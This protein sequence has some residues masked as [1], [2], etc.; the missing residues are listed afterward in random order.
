MNLHDRVN[1][2]LPL[3]RK[4]GRYLGNETNAFHKPWERAQIRAAMIFPDLYEIGMSHLGLHILY[5]ILN[6]HEDVLADRAYRPDTDMEELLRSKGIPLYGL[7]SGKP[8]AAFDLLAITLPYELCY[9][10]IPAILDLSGIPLMASDR[11]D[12]ALPLVLGGGSCACNP[13]PVA[14]LFDAIVLG[15]GEEIII[16]ITKA[17]MTWKGTGLPRQELLDTLASIPGIYV[18]SFYNPVYDPQG[19]FT[20]METRLPSGGAVQRRIVNDLEQAPF[21]EKPLTPIVNIVHDRLGVEIAR[22]CTRGCRFCQASSIYRP[23]RERSP[24]TVLGIIDRALKNSGWDEL[25]LLSLSTGDYGCLHQVIK[26]LMSRYLSDNISVSLPS[27]RVGTLTGEIMEEVKK[28]RKTGFTLAPEAGSERMRKVINKNITE[29]DLLE[30]AKNAYMNGWSNM[31]LYFMTGLPFET[32]ADVAEIPELARKVLRQGREAKGRRE[33]TISIGTFVP[34]PHTPFQWAAQISVEEAWKRIECVKDGIASRKIKVKWHDPG[35]SFLEGVF[36][37]GD[38]RLLPVIIRA[39]ETG[40]AL[41]AWSDHLKPELYHEAARELGVNLDAYLAAREKNMP[42][43]WDHLHTGITRDFLLKELEKAERQAATTDCRTGKCHRCGVCDLKELKPRTCIRARTV[44]GPT[45]KASDISH[46]GMNEKPFFF[47][48][49]YSKTGTARLMSHLETISAFHRAARRGRLPVA[50]SRGFHPMMRFS[51]ANPL[52]LG[53][54][55]TGEQGSVTLSSWMKPEYLAERLNNR[56]PDGLSVV[57]ISASGKKPSFREGREKI[58]LASFPDADNEAIEQDIIAFNGMKHLMV[59]KKTKRKEKTVDVRKAVYDLSIV[60]PET[61]PGTVPENDIIRQWI[62]N[63]AGSGEK[64]IIFC[65]FDNEKA[66]GIRPHELLR[67]ALSG[68]SETEI[69]CGRIIV[70]HGNT[71]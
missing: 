28:V 30:T 3:V 61:L 13:E 11:H 1:D 48:F 20:G 38:R 10:N 53:L 34:K 55:S 36:S 6:R 18:P 26:E 21:P 64:K 58:F 32:M 8:L 56:L 4:P 47:S 40:A 70:H 27:L 15:D 16:E 71:A 23:V 60:S 42:L 2:L 22:G 65:L 44:T 39:W 57:S 14:E 35:Q 9:S 62:D 41:D 50:F 37:R 49:L 7:E 66:C 63:T 43:P 69:T 46:D 33:V 59:T 17:M 19:R 68:L 54:E 45:G 24:E 52:P 31:K 51:F 5:D 12:P 29:E 67:A 25:S